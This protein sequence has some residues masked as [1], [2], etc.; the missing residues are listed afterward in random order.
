MRLL[1][2]PLVEGRLFDPISAAV[3]VGTNLIGGLI[4]AHAAS[5]AAQAQQQ[6]AAQAGQQVTAAAQQANAPITAAGQSAQQNALA[7]AG[8]VTQAAN[9]ASANVLNQSN[10]A[11]DILDQYS[12]AGQAAAGTLQQ[13]L[14]PGGDFNKTPTLQDLQIDPGY[15][16]RLNQGLQSINRSAAARGGAVSGA[17]LKDLTNYSQGSASQ[18]YQNAFNRFEQ[19]TQNRFNN[20]NTVS[21]SG[22]Q[23]GTTQGNNLNTSAQ[24]GGNITTGAA[25]ANLNA[26]EYAGTTGLQAAQSTGANTLGAAEQAGNYLTQGA[27]A[28]A[29]GKVGAANAFTGALSNG[30]NAYIGYNALANS[31]FS[32]PA[33]NLGA[34]GGVPTSVMNKIIGV[35]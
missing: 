11:N 28:A 15:Q 6:A 7:A 20:L 13:G 1:L 26:N 34:N 14:T 9:S 24:Y 19:S 27:N 30:A 18:E 3:G 12:Q 10:A 2:N 29:A 32:N 23:A 16:F 35:P 25:N 17:A 8:G 21:N 33:I 31:P 22:Q 4:G 5:S